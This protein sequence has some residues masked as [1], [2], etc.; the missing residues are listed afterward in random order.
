MN[1][2]VYLNGELLGVRPSGY[3]GFRY[4]LTPYI[5]FDAPNVIAVRVDNSRQP[6]SRWYSGSGIYR[7][8]W[9]TKVNPVHIPLWGTCITTPQVTDRRAVVDIRTTA[10]NS[11]ETPVAAELTSVLLD[12]KGNPRGSATSALVLRAGANGTISQQIELDNPVRWSID[13]P[14]LYTI[15][16]EIRTDNQLA[17]IYDTPF[18]IRTFRFDARQGFFLNEQAV[19]IKGVCL[20]HDLGCLGAAFNTRA[21]ERQLEILRG[22][23]CNS[24]RFSHNPPAPEM[25]GLCDRMGFIVMDEAFDVWRKKKTAYDYALHFNEWHERDLTDLILRDRN[26]PSV[27]MWSIGN[28][29]LE[30]WTHADA[31]TLTLQEANLILNAGHD[32]AALPRD[33]NTLSVNAL[34]TQKLAGIVRSLDPTRPVTAGSNEPSPNNHLFRSGALDIIGY[35]YHD[36]W[37]AD[38][39]A[40]FPGK[41][42]I[43][44]EATSALMTR[45]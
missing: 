32:E 17:D 43:I 25:L 11:G 27:M 45:G 39:P 4:D 28:E 8:V 44:T 9:L 13:N 15:R 41:P 1:A 3:I 24:I 10:V 16:T 12:D 22:M 33:D 37:F 38:V 6:N 23:G 35:N 36:Q 20:H 42:F 7:N 26:H 2:E 40:N 19:K 21:A 30:Q 29:V 18:G 34:L 14:H 5:R 31:D